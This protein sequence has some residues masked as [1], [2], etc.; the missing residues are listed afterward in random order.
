[1]ATQHYASA[2]HSPVVPDLTGLVAYLE[3]IANPESHQRVAEAKRAHDELVQQIQLREQDLHDVRQ[4]QKTC[5]DELSESETRARALQEQV[6][7]LQSEVAIERSKSVALQA[8]KDRRNQEEQVLL[9]QQEERHL[10]LKRLRSQQESLAL[11]VS[12]VGLSLDPW[13]VSRSKTRGL[14]AGALK[15]SNVYF[16]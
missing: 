4:Q 5:D 3:S 7:A 6:Q 1:M 9:T 11:L 10:E 14:M 16:L 13:K 15:K 2:P 12:K 8:E